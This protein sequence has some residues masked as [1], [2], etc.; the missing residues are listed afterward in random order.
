MIELQLY[1]FIVGYYYGWVRFQYM[2]F[3]VWFFGFILFGDWCRLFCFCLF[4]VVEEEEEMDFLDLVLRVFCGCILSMVNI[5]DVNVIILV[6]KNMLDC[7]EK[8]NEMLFNFNNL[9]SVCLQQMSE[10]F[11]YY[12]RILVEMKWDLDSIFCWI[13]MLKGKLVRQYLEVFSYILE[14]FF[15]E[16][17]DEDF[18]L[19]SIMIIIV[20]LEQ[21]MGLCD[22][23]FDIVLFFLSF[24]FEDLFYVQFGFLVINGC[25]QI[26]DEEMMGEQIYC[27]VF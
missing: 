20:I 26:D 12:I 9:F 23:S 3:L 24:G 22:I 7:F 21:S 1:I 2:G 18:I 4:Q 5:D 11:L 27:L 13:R 19:F 25:S 6:Q 17:E 15:L 8:I 10:C 14:V 16:E